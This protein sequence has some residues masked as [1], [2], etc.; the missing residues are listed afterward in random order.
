MA[1]SRQEEKALF[2]FNI[3]F[4][5]IDGTLEKGARSRIVREICGK[6][7]TIPYS[8]KRTLCPA[9]VWKWYRDYTSSGTI[10]SLR[11]ICENADLERL[12]FRCSF[13]RVL[14]LSGDLHY[15]IP[16][17]HTMK[18]RNPAGCSK[19]GDFPWAEACIPHDQ[20][21]AAPEQIAPDSDQI[22]TIQRDLKKNPTF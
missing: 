3:I 2:R 17:V 18:L 5:L 11:L 7:Y 1:I 8:T 16:C 12:P 13:D 4:P 15:G 14:K 10:D 6:E 20:E 21:I 9:T 19:C 22:C